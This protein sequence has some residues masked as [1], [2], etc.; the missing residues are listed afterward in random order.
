MVPSNPPQPHD[1][2]PTHSQRSQ[3]IGSFSEICTCGRSFSQLNALSHHQKT[4]K[5]T[6]T[7]LASALGKAQ[8]AWNLRKKRRFTTSNGLSLR[9]NGVGLQPHSESHCR[10]GGLQTQPA[11]ES[12]TASSSAQV[13]ATS[14]PLL[15]ICQSETGVFIAPSLPGDS[16][17]GSQNVTPNPVTTPGETHLEIPQ[18]DQ[19]LSLSI[20][21]RK[22]RRNRV[23][24]KRFRDV[25]PEPPVSTMHR[26]DTELSSPMTV[27]V[28]VGVESGWPQGRDFQTPRNVF[29]LFRR[30]L[31][32]D[33]PSHDPEDLT[34]L[35]DLCDSSMPRT[36]SSSRDSPPTTSRL[37]DRSQL[38]PYPNE[39]SFLLGNWYWGDG[40]QKSMKDFKQLIDIVGNP[41]FNP[42]DVR[43]TRWNHINDMLAQTSSD[44]N[45]GDEW[46]D[47]RD[48]WKSTPI[49]ISVPFHS[50]SK[51]PGPRDF[52]V[53]DFHHRSLTSVIREKLTNE[54]ESQQFHYEPY[55]LFWK[56]GNGDK[57][58]VRVYGELYMS[59]EF[60]TTH[61]R[62]IDSPGEPGCTLPRVVV[63]LMFHSDATHLTSFGDAKIWPLYLF[64][65]N[66][67]KYRRC[68]PTHHLCQHIA[69]FEKVLSFLINK[70]SLLT[71][72][73]W[74]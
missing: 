16:D 52:V 63:A 50:K 26:G 28:P 51:N 40:V 60:L 23:L 31:T 38:H 49:T 69:Y 58:E 59:T 42:N 46:E 7:R 37:Q 10:A 65:G 4:C 5:A 3:N 56:P 74:A 43:T 18:V 36:E 2:R 35:A 55:S 44:T 27:E 9:G 33:P 29:G 20:A 66:E 70:D 13:E 32:K 12:P 48:G 19:S 72:C 30:F 22:P 15:G 45:V 1:A 64:F 39:N 47:D 11:S 6:K 41:C 71:Q 57:K 61:Q 14:T 24:P 68:K 25:L 73:R 21:Q 53:P 17:L 67:S 62:L 54:A 34:T 8:E